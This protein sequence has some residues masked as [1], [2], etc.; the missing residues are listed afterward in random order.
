MLRALG[1]SGNIAEVSIASTRLRIRVRDESAVDAA[2]V[3]ALSP[4]GGVRAAPQLWHLIIGPGVERLA[5][6]LHTRIAN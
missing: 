6:E 1:G 2:Q 3:I 4:R 5:A